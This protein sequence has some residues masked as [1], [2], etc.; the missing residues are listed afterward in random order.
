M[1]SSPT[2]IES[3]VTIMQSAFLEQPTLRP[4][5]AGAQRR[6]RVDTATC[7]AVVGSLVD[8]HELEERDGTYRR[9]F[10]APRRATGGVTWAHRMKPVLQIER[11]PGL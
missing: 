7:A 10:P 4:T 8:A 3:L 11:S 2:R 9:H 6:F 5:L 1:P